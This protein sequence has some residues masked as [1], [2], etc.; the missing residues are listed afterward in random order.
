MEKV[1]CN[2]DAGIQGRDVTAA[3]ASAN[4]KGE[5]GGDSICCSGSWHIL[6]S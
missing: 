1:G 3:V 4:R 6:G 5:G 2:E